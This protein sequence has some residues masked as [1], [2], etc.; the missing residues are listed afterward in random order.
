MMAGKYVAKIRPGVGG[1]PKGTIPWNK[2]KQ[3]KITWGANISK[4]TKGIPKSE[5]HKRKIGIANTGKKHTELTKKKISEKAKG[6]IPYN[7]GVRK[8]THPQIIKY[9]I[10]KEKHWNWKGGISSFQSLL[11]QTSEYKH[12]RDL[13][14]QR[15]N[16]ICQFCE[17]HKRELV[18]HHII[19]M[20]TLLNLKNINHLLW[21]E[22]IFAPENGYTLCCEC[23]NNFHKE[24][25]C[26]N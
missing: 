6:R 12:W 9:G 20:K 11:R 16:Y 22:L 15:D 1:V 2:G 17:K 25:H 7:K 4:A 3:R 10:S 14:F 24:V 26:A 5:E 18:A 13:V 21:D 8:I 19:P 23:H